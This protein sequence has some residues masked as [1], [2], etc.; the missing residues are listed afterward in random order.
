MRRLKRRNLQQGFIQAVLLFGIA[1]MTI[2][3]AGFA[4]ANRN[5]SG[6]LSEQESK[7]LAGLVLQQGT[8]LSAAVNAYMQDYNSTRVVNSMNFSDVTTDSDSLFRPDRGYGS[9]QILDNPKAYADGT[10]EANADPSD[11]IAG[12][13]RLN[14]SISGNGLGGADPEVSVVLPN[15][16]LE[17][18]EAINAALYGRD[19][20]APVTVGGSMSGASGDTDGSAQPTALDISAEADLERVDKACIELGADEYMYYQVVLE[21]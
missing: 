10:Y 9:V 4:L 15:L 19:N 14:K 13:W 5:P 20:Q 11:Y 2:V 12:S 7:V 6:N 17:L 18:C 1:L 8:A 21:R 16:T 3:L